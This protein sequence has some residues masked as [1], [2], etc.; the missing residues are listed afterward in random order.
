M[1]SPRE[2]IYVGHLGPIPLYVH[3]SALLLVYFAVQ[4]ANTSRGFDAPL[5]LLLLTVLIMGIVLHELGHGLTAKALG[6][7]GVT[8]TLWAFGGL[9][10]STRDSL[11][12][13]ELLIVAAGPAVSFALAAIGYF[14]PELIERIQPG[15][16]IDNGNPSL[17]LEFLYYTY[18]INLWMGIFNVLPIYP[19]DG[20]QL[21]FNFMHLVT[22]KQ[23]IARKVCLTLAVFG[24]L[25]FILY[26]FNQNGNQFDTNMIYTTVLMGYLVHNAF[27]YLR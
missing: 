14:G 11:P 26:R 10:K 27:N 9:C 25:A 8:I 21:V 3:W 16:L 17:L 18:L 23:L 24:A 2:G 1:I 22:G 15:W 5:F 13:R 20:G 7:F 19:L 12:R 6:A 4:W